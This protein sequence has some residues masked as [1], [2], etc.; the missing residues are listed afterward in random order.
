MG[1]IEKDIINYWLKSAKRDKQTAKILF[2]NEK[3]D[4]CLLEKI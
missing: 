1:K 2:D 3:Y 4:Q